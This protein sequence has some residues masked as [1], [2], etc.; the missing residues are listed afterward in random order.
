VD[1][2]DTRR[3]SESDDRSS[4]EIEL[5]DS[6]GSVSTKKTKEFKALLSTR[7]GNRKERKLFY[8]TR[9]KSVFEDVVGAI[10]QMMFMLS[11]ISCHIPCPN[12]ISTTAV[13]CVERL[14]LNC[15]DRYEHGRQ[16]D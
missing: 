2:P 3:S 13:A 16:N 6:I 10:F 8:A 9:M 4:S 11:S 12:A 14:T 1:T 7:Q 15:W 5:D